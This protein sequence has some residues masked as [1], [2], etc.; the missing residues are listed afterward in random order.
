MSSV[1]DDGAGD[2][3][4]SD[5]PGVNCGF[6]VSRKPVSTNDA[7]FEG[8]GIASGGPIDVFVGFGI[9]D[10]SLDC[11]CDSCD[12]DPDKLWRLPANDR[13][14]LKRD[15][16]IRTGEEAIDAKEPRR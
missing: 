11:D 2:G 1:D 4:V 5:C 6:S 14:E 10:F 15:N 8:G 13:R 3:D 7:R 12:L 9:S 16:Q